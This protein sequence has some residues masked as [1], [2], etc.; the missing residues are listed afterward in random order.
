VRLRRER[1]SFSRPTERLREPSKDHKVGVKLDAVQATD[2]QREKAVVVFQ[3]SELALHGCTPPVEVAEPLSVTRDTRE[4]PT[5]DTRHG[6][7]LTASATERDDRFTAA[8]FALGIDTVVVVALVRRARFGVDAASVERIEKRGDEQRL[9]PPRR[10]DAPRKRQTRRDA[11][12]GVNLVPVIPAARASRDSG[13]VAPACIR[14]TEPL[15]F[16]ASMTDVALTIRVSGEVG[17]VYRYVTPKSRVLLLQRRDAGVDAVGQNRIV[18]CAACWRSGNR[19]TRWAL[20][21]AALAGP[22]VQRS[23]RQPTSKSGCRTGL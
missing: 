5:A 8:R 10:L 13:T 20:L 18:S 11:D 16:F 2:A 4:Q 1:Y 14:I 7:L 22:D 23:A 19:P 3:L 6:E 15:A 9:L 21:R 12:S 17:G